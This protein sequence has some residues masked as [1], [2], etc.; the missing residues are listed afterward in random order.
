M[1]TVSSVHVNAALTTLAI[2]YKNLELV[3]ERVF[4][5]V[6]VNKESDTYYVFNKEE[7]VV[8]DSERAAGAEAREITWDVT[9]ATYT[10]KEYA[11]SHLVPDRVM[12]NADVAVRPQI[13]STQ[14]LLRKILLGKEKRIANLVQN[15]ANV[16]S[17]ATPSI[18]WDGTSPTIE[19]DIDTAKDTVRIAAGVEP[20]SMVLPYKV[21]N[22]F[23]RDT[24]IRDLIRYQVPG[25]ILLRNGELP[26]VVFN[27][28]V[29]IAGAIRNTANEGA[30]ESLADI[31]TD[32][33]LVFYKEPTPS[34]DA[35]SLGYIFRVGNPVVS[36]Y[37]VDLRKGVMIEVSELSAE[38]VVASAC[39]YI[40]SDVLA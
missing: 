11:L 30:T 2:G 31:W 17:S 37:R 4:P 23:K 38:K 24:T 21:K 18:K 15:T 5:I 27:L 29:I 25:D 20:T 40:I 32:N 39:G 19:K 28:E 26:P 10:A 6:P 9:T 1:P 36:T 35:L 8:E 33:V 12:N 3:G 16:G 22:A 34:L 7:L 13:S 14:K